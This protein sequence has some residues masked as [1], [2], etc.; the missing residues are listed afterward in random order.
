MWVGNG[1]GS[2]KILTHTL[3]V[4]LN[5]IPRCFYFRRG[6]SIKKLTVKYLDFEYICMLQERYPLNKITFIAKV[7]QRRNLKLISMKYTHAHKHPMK[8]VMSIKRVI[9]QIKL[10]LHYTYNLVLKHNFYII[11][12]SNPA[13]LNP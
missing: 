3:L 13:H 9:Y 5:E 8:T 6:K 1:G 10:V 4:H 2:P 11:L 7:L 12:S